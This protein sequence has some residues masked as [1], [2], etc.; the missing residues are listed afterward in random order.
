MR[1]K[2][3]RKVMKMASFADRLVDAF[4]RA[5]IWLA[6]K[7][8]YRTR[9]RFF[10]A[11]TGY[12]LAPLGGFIA[13]A[14]ANLRYV[15]P[16]MPL[17]EARRIARRV[18]VNL[19]KTVIENYCKDD[20]VA[21]LR[22]RPAD[23]PGLAAFHQAVAEGR[24]VLIV[25]GHLGNHETLRVAVHL[26]GHPVA[27]LYRPAKNPH[28]NA[29]YKTTMETITGPAFAQGR[30]GIMAFTRH[31]KNGGIAAMLFDVRSARY[32]DIDFLGH[33]AP[34]STFA[35]E[36]ALKTGALLLPVFTHRLPDGI[37]H[38]VTFEAPIAPSNPHDMTV[39]MTRR[40]EAQV[41]RYPDQWLWLHDRWGS[42]K[43]RAKRAQRREPK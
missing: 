4:L 36:M 34:T 17:P 23:G 32:D 37:T 5:A 24:P 33:P 2:A 20:L 1:G 19:G 21:V 22:D 25:S 9:V 3:Q 26:M 10:G 8:P 35:A 13:K 14:T 41:R 31:V 7:I 15:H 28:F 27:A 42:E 12:V 39:E 29:H 11:L 38:Q 16:D 43:M 6:R 40:L 30:Q 18:A